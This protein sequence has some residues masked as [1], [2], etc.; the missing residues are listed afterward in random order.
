V[1]PEQRRYEF[2]GRISLGGL[3]AGEVPQAMVTPA[4]SARLWRPEFQGL[5]LVG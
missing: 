1:G 2:A 5:T 4:G 3:L